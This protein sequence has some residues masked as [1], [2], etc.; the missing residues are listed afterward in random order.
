MNA[1]VGVLID[2][3]L[4]LSY[5]GVI[6]HA[7]IIYISIAI[8]NG[9]KVKSSYFGVFFIYFYYLN[10]SF[11]S[12]LYLTHGLLFL[13]VFFYLIKSTHANTSNYPKL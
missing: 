7:F 5:L 6:L 10:T 1:N 3:F 8:I 11:L 13:I 2:G 4:N 12:T 9:I